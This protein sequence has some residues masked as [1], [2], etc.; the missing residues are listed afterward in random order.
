MRRKVDFKGKLYDF[1]YEA[2]NC[3]AKLYTK[4]EKS[5]VYDRSKTCLS[6]CHEEDVN[7]EHRRASNAGKSKATKH[8]REELAHFSEKLTLRRKHLFVIVET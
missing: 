8:P 2:E 7:V 3:G 5:D 4:G 6:Y 1:F